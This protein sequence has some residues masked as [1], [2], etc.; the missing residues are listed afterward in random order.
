MLVPLVLI[1]MVDDG[2]TETELRKNVHVQ[3]L[4]CVV[5]PRG[6]SECENSS[7]GTINVV[8]KSQKWLHTYT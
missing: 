1:G 6:V 5:E 4:A 7:R 8:W 3:G 2:H